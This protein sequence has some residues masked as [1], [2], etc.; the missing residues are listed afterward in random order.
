LR[1]AI[2]A[3]SAKDF[4]SRASS[5]VKGRRSKCDAE[6]VPYTWSPAVIAALSI[7]AFR[8]SLRA[9]SRRLSGTSTPFSRSG[10]YE[11]LPVSSP[12]LA[13]A[14]R[15]NRLRKAST[16]A[17]QP[18]RQWISPS[19]PTEP[20]ARSA[21]GSSRCRLAQMLSN[22]GCASAIERLMAASTSA[23]AVWRS[24]AAR[25]SLNSCAFCSAIAA[26]SAKVCSSATSSSA[27]GRGGVRT[28]I[29]VP[30]TRPCRRSGT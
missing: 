2:T 7:D 9:A 15:G 23:L 8:P 12:A 22:T 5:S 28:K 11:A 6:I 17:P 21:P 29:N 4:S 18:E 16:A 3:W 26:W 14:G 25:V 30:S 24:S 10:K 19:S 1:I 20:I 27:K 13:G